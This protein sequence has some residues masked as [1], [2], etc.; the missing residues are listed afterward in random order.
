MLEEG[1]S[2]AVFSGGETGIV[3]MNLT[4][5][6]KT[7]VEFNAFGDDSLV[8]QLERDNERWLL[9]ALRKVK[10]AGEDKYQD[11]F[12]HEVEVDITAMVKENKLPITLLRDTCS[13]EWLLGD[14]TYTV[15]DLAFPS[16][17]DDMA[18][19][20]KK[21]QCQLIHADILSPQQSALKPE[22]FFIPAHSELV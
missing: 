11:T 21:G 7:K 4:M 6:D 8:Y 19:I 18:L 12:G 16:S 17:F 1:H 14:G 13:I 9:R 20:V 10:V 22:H 2:L 3:E 5:T 15:T